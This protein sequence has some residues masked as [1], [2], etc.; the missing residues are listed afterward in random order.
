MT[1]PNKEQLA[2]TKESENNTTITR[3]NKVVEEKSEIRIRMEATL[4]SNY[5]PY[6]R[7]YRTVEKYTFPNE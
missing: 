6:E 3:N 5:W 7:F 1:E 4:K 2:W